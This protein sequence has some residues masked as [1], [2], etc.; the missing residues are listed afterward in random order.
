M[1]ENPKKWPK[2]RKSARKHEKVAIFGVLGGVPRGVL[3]GTRVSQFRGGSEPPLGGP[4]RPQ[5]GPKR[6]K[7]RKNGRK[8]GKSAEIRGNREKSGEIGAS[9]NPGHM[10][11]PWHS[12]KK[13]T[14]RN[15]SIGIEGEKSLAVSVFFVNKSTGQGPNDPSEGPKG[16]QTR[17]A[18]A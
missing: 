6:P 18:N 14:L 9:G 5:N 10:A 11:F 16:P 3:G 12:G 13:S 2:T 7:S 15:F 17:R 1:P 8:H 4:Q